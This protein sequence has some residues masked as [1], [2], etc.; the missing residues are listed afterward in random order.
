[1]SLCKARFCHYC[2]ELSTVHSYVNLIEREGVT[3]RQSQ[4]Q[5]PVNCKKI[6]TMTESLKLVYKSTYPS[7]LATLLR[8]RNI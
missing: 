6:T 4:V 7:D 2:G 1:M 3:L 5:G 8:S